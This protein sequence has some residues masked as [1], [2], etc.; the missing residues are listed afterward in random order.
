MTIRAMTLDDLNVVL[1]W[2][3]DEGW[4]PGLDDA[5]AFHAADPAGFLIKEVDGAPAAAISVVNHD[6]DVA[7][8][9]LYLCKPAFRGQG[10]GIDVWRAGIAHA[11]ARSIGLDGVPDQQENYAVSGFVKYGST[12]RYE[13]LIAPRTD[14][15]IRQ[16]ASGDLE[17][18]VSRDAKA[19]GTRRTAFARA[20]F[21]D[22]LTRQTMVL[23][24][25]A[26][27]AGFATFRRC[28]SGSKIGPLYAGSDADA[29]ALLSANPF[30]KPDLPCSIDI[31]DQNAPLAQVVTSLNFEPTFETA[32]MFSGTPPAA[33][34]AKFQAIATMELG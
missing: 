14:A 2:A 31:V 22:T 20:W 9:G 13:G 12:V 19:T 15:R 27:I 29:R 4:N 24:K 32:R 26:G 1:Q 7:F 23:I 34:P 6:P 8:L 10:H 17:T 18:L 11:G 21:T 25:G 5:P 28:P 16:A 33:H 30:G 3:A